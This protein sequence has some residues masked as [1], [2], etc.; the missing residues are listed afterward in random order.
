MASVSHHTNSHTD[1]GLL[2]LEYYYN[3]RTVLLLHFASF[4][5]QYFLSSVQVGE[6]VSAIFHSHGNSPLWGGKYYINYTS[7]KIIRLNELRCRGCTMGKIAEKVL[8]AILSRILYS[9]ILCDP[10]LHIQTKDY[11]SILSRCVHVMPT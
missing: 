4:L 3:R 7:V 10:S 8:L 2:W 1:I 11:A 9:T 5:M 6:A